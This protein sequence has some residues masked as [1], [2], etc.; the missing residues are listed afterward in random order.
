MGLSYKDNLD[1]EVRIY[2]PQGLPLAVAVISR[3]VSCAGRPFFFPGL[4]HFRNASS[5]L[6][7]DID[8]WTGA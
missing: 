4:A 5:F 6:C 7:E 2:E 1:R 8:G 3:R